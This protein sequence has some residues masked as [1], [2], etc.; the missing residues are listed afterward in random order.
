M[1]LQL[2]IMQKNPR[3]PPGLQFERHMTEDLRRSNR[4]IRSWIER[5]VV[6]KNI[7]KSVAAL[8]VSFVIAG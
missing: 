1:C 3:D 2:N 8:G 5:S 4:W 6:W 7:I